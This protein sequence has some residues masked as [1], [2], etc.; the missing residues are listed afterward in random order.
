MTLALW[1][2]AVKEAKKQ[3]GVKDTFTRIEGKLLKKCQVIYTALV[4]GTKS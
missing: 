1:D 4:A 3:M 2:E